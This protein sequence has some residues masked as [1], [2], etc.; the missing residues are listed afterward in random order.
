MGWVWCLFGKN[1]VQKSAIRKPAWHLVISGT[2]MRIET[3]L[4]VGKP[5]LWCKLVL[6]VVF[7]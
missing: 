3:L 6:M 5:S 2:K 4:V 7:V 1:L